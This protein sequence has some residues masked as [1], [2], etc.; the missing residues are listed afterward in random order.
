M[1]LAY[2]SSPTSVYLGRLFILGLA[3]FTLFYNLCWHSILDFRPWNLSLL[4]LEAEVVHVL[5]HFLSLYLD[6][7]RF[8]IFLCTVTDVNIF[9]ALYLHPAR[10]LNLPIRS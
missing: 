9:Q 6:I 10:V 8:T 1:S 7:H 5:S 2:F 4:I 3:F